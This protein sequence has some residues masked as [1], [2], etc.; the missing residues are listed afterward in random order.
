MASTT[1]SAYQFALRTPRDPRDVLN[2]VA[3]RELGGIGVAERGKSYVVL[4]PRRRYR[5]SSDIAV[6][7]GI[8]IL[9]VVLISTAISPWLIIFSPLAFLPGVPLWFDHRPTLA[10]S[11]VVEEETGVTRVTAHG[12]ASPE[13]SA[14]LDAYFS[15][16]P[17]APMDQPAGPST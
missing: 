5:Y 17:V 8:A 13:L 16:L 3:N 14:A 9:L 12:E 7:A 4:R 10:V 1:T 15:T 6:V 2:E 11:A